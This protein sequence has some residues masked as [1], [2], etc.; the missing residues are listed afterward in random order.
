MA[1]LPTAAELLGLTSRAEWSPAVALLHQGAGST[2]DHFLRGPLEAVGVRLIE[3]DSA[4]PPDPHH[5]RLLE[6]CVTIV[7]VRYLPR[8]W[9][10]PLSRLRLTGTRLV[11]LMDDDLLDPEAHVL[12][13][14]EYRRRLWERITRQRRR[15]P[16]LVDRIWVTSDYLAAKYASLSVQQ[17][18]LAPHASL[19]AIRPRVQLAYLGTSVHTEEFAWLFPLLQELQR[20][21]SS[22][23]VELFGDLSVNR[24]FRA[25]PRVRILH[26][27]QWD[28]YLAE[29]GQGRIDILLTPL[30]QAPFNA[31][32]APVKLIDAARSGAAGLYSDRPPY[33]GFVRDG[34][35]GL[36]LDDQ[37]ESWLT[38]IARLIADPQERRRLA[39]G[40]RQRARD[41]CSGPGP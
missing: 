14:R 37:H 7:V 6:G 27:M 25:L 11:Y 29:T 1:L 17:L 33:Q 19:L 13:P 2:I 18:A 41:L 39:Q 24:R 32:R 16:A 20:R 31:A 40:A 21:H 10:G 12:L 9:I 4:I 38:V 34:A 15:L 22:T 8:S 3:I 5:L 35:D 26:P 36:L 30:L 23:H 28:N